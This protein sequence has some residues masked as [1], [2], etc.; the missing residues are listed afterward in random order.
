METI[1]DRVARAYDKYWKC[2][3]KTARRLFYSES[4]P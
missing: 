2:G 3:R 1:V 4:P